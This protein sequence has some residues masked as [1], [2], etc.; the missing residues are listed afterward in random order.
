MIRVHMTKLQTADL[1]S[2]KYWKIDHPYENRNK[3]TRD[4]LNEFI[5]G[6]FGDDRYKALPQTAR[7]WLDGYIDAK[8]GGHYVNGHTFGKDEMIR[9]YRVD[10]VW[11]DGVCEGMWSHVDLSRDVW[12]KTGVVFC[13]YGEENKF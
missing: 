6:V 7:N 1:D 5:W 11:Q 3:Y 2:L 4:E 12:R 8:F 10:G 13:E 9:Q